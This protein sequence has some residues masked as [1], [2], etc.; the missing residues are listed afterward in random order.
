MPGTV[1][2]A[3]KGPH[4]LDLRVFR[5]DPFHEPVL[6]GGTRE[7]KRGVETKRVTIKGVAHP[8]NL[9]PGAEM[10]GG[11][12][13]TPN[14]DADFWEL[15]LSQNKDSQIVTSGMIFAHAKS[16]DAQGEA[17]NGAKER[18]GLEPLAQDGDPRQPRSVEKEKKAA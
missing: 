9:P 6:G 8:I 7:T 2:V 13:L 4:G 18:S 5:M 11:Y 1:T 16:A 15:W 3:Y 17:R 10:I 14:V 12:A